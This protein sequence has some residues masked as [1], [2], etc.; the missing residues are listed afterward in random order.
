MDL[1]TETGIPLGGRKDRTEG[2]PSSV[3]GSGPAQTGPAPWGVPTP[4]RGGPAT[5][6]H[7]FFPAEKQLQKDSL[8]GKWISFFPLQT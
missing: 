4:L 6:S 2:G 5:L 8:S 7:S 3:R 1:N